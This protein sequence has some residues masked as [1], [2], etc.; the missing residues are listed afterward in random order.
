M[1]FWLPTAI[2]VKKRAGFEYLTK[3]HY[4]CTIFLKPKNNNMKRILISLIMLTAAFQMAVAQINYSKR[5]Q[6]GVS[7]TGRTL[8]LSD[9]SVRYDWTGTY[10]QTDFT[11]GS[12]AIEVSDTKKTYHNLF[13][14]GKL[15]RRITIEGERPQRIV[16]A[17]GLTRKPHRLCLQRVTEGS[18]GCTTIHGFYLAQ[19][20]TLQQV[21]PRK[22]F[23]EFYGDSYTCGYG[24]EAAG[25]KEKFTYE[26]ED[27][28]HAY[29]CLIARYF[30]ADYAAIA[31]SGMGMVRNYGD[32]KQTSDYTMLDR[33][34]HLFDNFDTLRYDFQAYKPQL[35]CIQLGTNDFSRNNTPTV[36]QYCGNYQK[37]IE[38]LRKAYGDIPILCILPY[39]AGA[40]LQT[41][42]KELAHR[43]S[44]DEHVYIAEPMLKV[45]NNPADLGADWHPNT[46]GQQKIAMKLIPQISNIMGW[47]LENKVIE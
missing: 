39:S 23:I 11:G 10:L 12:I 40:Y 19:G 21:A 46:Q 28:N 16:L 18:G 2:T 29:A 36:E 38:N 31:H 35:V 3:K 17:K 13:I 27:F 45:I 1:R 37:F 8:A 9:G 32:K 20:G 5:L 41:A 47:K 4:F 33:Q 25:P 44:Y 14:D 43:M 34:G 26:T 7:Y 30:E 15:I 42:F 6:Q 22:R 24:T